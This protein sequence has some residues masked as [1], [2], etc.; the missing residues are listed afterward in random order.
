MT[1]HYHIPMVISGP[2]G[3]DLRKLSKQ[4]TKELREE[5]I[6]KTC[7]EERMHGWIHAMVTG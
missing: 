2:L 4:M 7:T 5:G 6:E 1:E 3:E